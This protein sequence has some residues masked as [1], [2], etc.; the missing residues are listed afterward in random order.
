MSDDAQPDAQADARADAR[1]DARAAARLIRETRHHAEDTL[2]IKLPRMYAAWGVAWLIGLGAMWLSVRGQHPYTG[3]SGA[4]E[5]VL[6]GLLALALVV[7]M[8]AIGQATRG[9][10]GSSA[11]QGT[12]YGLSWPAGMAAVFIIV[13]AL[14]H[15]GASPR[16]LGVAY[17]AGPLLV[18]GLIY[19]TGS[20]I[21]LDRVMFWTGL[22]LLTITAAGAWT[23][24]AGLL[25][26]G[27][28]AGGGGFLAA[29][30]L[31]AFGPGRPE[32]GGPGKA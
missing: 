30:A 22:W 23:G 5:A 9:V 31:L 28:L 25:L 3:P 21:W 24:P 10:G 13:G 29:A 7:T 11:R 1:L 16:V 4:A 26:T 27:A 6:G 17:A 14:G 18:T 2:A 15:A 20:A 32:P 8:A 12:L 19:V